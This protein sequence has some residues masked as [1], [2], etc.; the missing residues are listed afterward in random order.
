MLQH[1]I[2]ISLFIV[3]FFLYPYC[4][5]IVAHCFLFITDNLDLSIQLSF[6]MHLFEMTIKTPWILDYSLYFTQNLIMT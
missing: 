4:L 6:L 5:S 2:Y 3:V 1:T